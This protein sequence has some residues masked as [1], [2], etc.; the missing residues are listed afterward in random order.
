MGKIKPLIGTVLPFSDMAKGHT[1]MANA[2][3]IGK[4]ITTP[5]KL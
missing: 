4:I 2:E 3:Q 1:M 5:Q